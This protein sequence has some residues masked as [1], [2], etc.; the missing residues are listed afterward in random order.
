MIPI[1]AIYSSNV[2]MFSV[3]LIAMH[4]RPK[5]HFLPENVVPPRSI[6]VVF[7][8]PKY[9]YKLQ[10]CFKDYGLHVLMQTSTQTNRFGKL[11]SKNCQQMMNGDSAILFRDIREQPRWN[12]FLKNFSR[13]HV[14]I[15]NALSPRNVANGEQWT[16]AG[17][18]PPFPPL[19]HR[20]PSPTH[21]HPRGS[22]TTSRWLTT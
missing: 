15:S 9:L 8:L 2:V 1:Y 11:L 14:G 6:V 17:C 16:A 22:H 18:F 3:D 20:T 21:L 4:C 7:N 12:T 5:C 19:S 10:F 13:R